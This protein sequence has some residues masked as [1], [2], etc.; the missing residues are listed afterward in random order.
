MLPTLERSLRNHGVQFERTPIE[1]LLGNLRRIIA[2]WLGQLLAT[3]LSLV[4]TA[5]LTMAQLRSRAEKLPNAVRSAA[6]LDL[7]EPV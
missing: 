7:F 5:G 4:K 1:R 3:F 6:F 2:S